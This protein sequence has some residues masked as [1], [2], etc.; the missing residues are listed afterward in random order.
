[1]SLNKDYRIVYTPKNCTKYKYKRFF[2]LAYQ[3]SNY[4][5]QENVNKC[6]LKAL[7]MQTDKITLRFR[8]Y[9]KIEIY[10]K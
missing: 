1:M 6:V 9:G 3:L 10:L 8:K 7:S 4:I 5:S 2:V